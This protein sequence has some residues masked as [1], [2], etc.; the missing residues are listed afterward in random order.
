MSVSYEYKVIPAPQRGRSGKG[1]R[2]TP[3]KFANEM[4]HLMNELGAEGWEYLRADTLPCE[5]RQGLTGKQVTFQHIL[6]FRR[7]MQGSRMIGMD[8]PM[9]T[10]GYQGPGDLTALPVPGDQNGIL[11]ILRQRKTGATYSAKDVAAE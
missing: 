4:M 11:G 5:E 2:G 1:V 10:I 3:A 6:V 7:P 8:R 9:K